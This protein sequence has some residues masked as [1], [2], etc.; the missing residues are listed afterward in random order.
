MLHWL[1]RMQLALALLVYGWSKVFLMQMGRADLG[2]A[3]VQFGEMSPMGLLWRFMAFSP[4]VQVLSGL[5]EVVAAGLLLLRRTAWLGGL[6]AFAS[7]AVVFLLNLTFD[8]PVKQLALYLCLCGA[9][10]AA[11]SAP[12]L[13]RVLRGRATGPRPLPTAVPWPSVHAVTRWLGLAVAVGALVVSGTGFAVVMRGGIP[14][15]SSPL[16]GAHRVVQD[17]AEPAAQLSQDTRWQ[18][19][20]FG[21]YAQDGWSRIGIRYADGRYQEGTYRLEG[22]RLTVRLYPVRE[23]SQG[24][25]RDHERTLQLGWQEVGD[26]R[27]R[28]SGEGLDLTIAPD[29]EATYLF[30]R[31]FRWAPSTPINR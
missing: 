27:V 17:S 24:L 15:T 29:A 18:Q 8:V 10:V 11:P 16:T 26:G 7:M 31:G 19:V 13:W 20:A 6:L 14:V 28:L 5:A 1:V 25:V 2:D 23:G 12:Y 9:V 4:A 30:D 22:E 3:L 21:Q